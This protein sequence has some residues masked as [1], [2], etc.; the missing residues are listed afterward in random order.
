[1]KNNFNKAVE[2]K[3]NR[4]ILL[5]VI[6][7]LAIIAL[8]IKANGQPKTA[9]LVTVNHQWKQ[10]ELY[11]VDSTQLDSICT[12]IS[13]GMLD[14]GIMDSTQFIELRTERYTLYI[15]RKEERQDGSLRRRKYK[16]NKK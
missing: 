3:T 11:K 13:S 8:S 15:E 10:M 14:S 4:M 12:A 6:I 1:M 9:Y 16:P 2:N 5:V 7:L